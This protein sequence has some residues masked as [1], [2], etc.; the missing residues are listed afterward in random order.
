MYNYIIYAYIHTMIHGKGATPYN[1]TITIVK[2][3]FQRLLHVLNFKAISLQV[4]P[5]SP[6][7][8]SSGSMETIN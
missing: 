5:K 3:I 6:L 8:Y 2:D 4:K 7:A 1:T